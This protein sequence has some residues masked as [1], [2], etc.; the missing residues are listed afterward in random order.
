[1]SIR[2]MKETETKRTDVFFSTLKA[3]FFKLPVMFQF[4]KGLCF[5]RMS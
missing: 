5:L 3:S 2:T 4:Q 1:M